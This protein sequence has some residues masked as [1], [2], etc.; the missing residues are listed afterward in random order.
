MVRMSRYISIFLVMFFL[1]GCTTCNEVKINSVSEGIWV[2]DVRHR[3]CGR[4][5]GYSVAL[6]R[7][8]ESLTKS[9]DGDKEPFQAI[10]DSGNYDVSHVPINIQWESDNH[11]IIHHDT[12]MFT[13]EPESKP[14]IIKAETSYQDVIIEYVPEPVL[15]D[16]EKRGLSLN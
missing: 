16:K 14:M 7:R 3:V 5:S 4:Y 2:A 8:N 12:R 10:Y 15:W 1:S 11:L 6:H 13:D 9:G